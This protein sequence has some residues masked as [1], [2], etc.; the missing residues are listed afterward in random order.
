MKG[1]RVKV[2]RA[3]EDDGKNERDCLSKR[4]HDYENRYTLIE[5]SCFSLVWVVQN[6]RH[7]IL[8]FQVWIV[9]KMEPL[10]YFFENLP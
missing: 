10:E 4:L 1:R 8:P 5:K 7:I 6:L 2:F 9:A 3:P